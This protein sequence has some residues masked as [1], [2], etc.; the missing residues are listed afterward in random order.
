MKSTVGECNEGH[1][2]LHENV[3]GQLYM[4]AAC[5]HVWHT[6]GVRRYDCVMILNSSMNKFEVVYKI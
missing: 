1:E 6:D 4:N 5:N 3:K 2:T